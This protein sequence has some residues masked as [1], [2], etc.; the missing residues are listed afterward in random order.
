M[1]NIEILKELPLFRG[2]TYMEFIQINKI[3][4]RRSFTK[5]ET[6]IKEDEEGESLFIIKSGSVTV[7]KKNEEDVDEVVAELGPGD[8][9]GEM[10]LIDRFPRSATV[11]ANEPSE[12]LEIKKSQFAELLSS[13]KEIDFKFSKAFNQVLCARL[14]ETTID[15]THLRMLL[16]REKKG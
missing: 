7:T 1:E 15:L 10:A 13:H 5:G 2:L 4:V 12:L 3:I 16:Q 11:T 6:I 8:P 14:R 9:F